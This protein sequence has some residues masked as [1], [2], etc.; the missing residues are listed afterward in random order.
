MSKQTLQK[1]IVNLVSG[2]IA[3]FFIIYSLNLIPFYPQDSRKLI[4]IAVGFLW[5]LNPILGVVAGLGILIIPITYTSLTLT[6]I[7]LMFYLIVAILE[8]WAVGP[9][10]FLVMAATV[11][12]VL[13]P[14]I[15]FLLLAIPLIAGFMGARR[16]AVLAAFS[17]F[18]AL[19][20]GLLIG[21]S[22]LGL[23]SVSS[24]IK[25]IIHLNSEPVTKMFGS[26]W[27]IA[28]TQ[29][30]LIDTALFKAVLSPFGD[31]PELL[32]Q[33]AL[34]A[35]AAGLIGYF[36]KKP[37]IKKFP[38]YE[39][40]VVI[41][42]ALLMIGTGLL[43]KAFPKSNWFMDK[44]IVSTL[45]P[46]ALVCA[47]SPG[48]IWVMP[49]ITPARKETTEEEIIV[50]SKWAE[51]NGLEQR[52]KEVKKIIDLQFNSQTR[53]NSAKENGAPPRGILFF[54]PPGTE[55]SK[56][57][58]GIADE[59]K[60]TL[61]SVNRNDLMAKYYD[62]FVSYSTRDKVAADT[63][64]ELLEKNKIH[65]WYAPRDIKPG[66]DWGKEVTNAINL[67]KQILLIF[68]RNS[69]CSQR[70][71]DEINYGIS[72]GISILPFRIENVAPNDTLM[73]HLSSRH[74]LNAFEPT[75][76]DYLDELLRLITNNLEDTNREGDSSRVQKEVDVNHYLMK[77]FEEA[78]EHH[79]SVL[80]F[81]ELIDFL[82]VS[83]QN[84]SSGISID[85]TE[86]FMEF[87]DQLANS[88]GILVVAATEYP[89]KIDEA[90]LDANRF[91]HQFYLTPPDRSTCRSILT[92]HLADKPMA[93]NVDLNKLS[94]LLDG[95]S[96][97][98][99]EALAIEMADLTESTRGTKQK[100]TGMSDFEKIIKSRKPMYTDDS[101]S[102][103]ESFAIEH[104]CIKEK[105]KQKEQ[106][107]QPVLKD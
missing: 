102:K 37:L 7:L 36:I 107:L 76:K 71:L 64:V 66:A 72:Q 74:W 23:I 106:K 1:T 17:G 99:I 48:L 15:H 21:K 96:L 49:I 57:A 65:C 47:A 27:L 40:A 34:W 39:S 98:D 4:A 18:L 52:Q 83:N 86:T 95:Y 104:G 25:P 20:L 94:T 10:G 101:L 88:P 91:G 16:G 51:S 35:V 30:G 44:F 56:V 42:M 33:I 6:I 3:C 93:L 9:F 59:A 61:I 63:C 5:F 32:V 85:S 73:L 43:P 2:V 8:T 78:Q 77:V 58:R 90:L 80:F 105:Q 11:I 100:P 81:E 41:G 89:E 19:S 75:W 103:Y 46:F 60:A 92:K 29:E 70:V 67:S 62:V 84:E 45:V 31:H 79:P 54:G 24:I 12:I 28:Q 13:H 69:N 68:S 82:G 53:K 97:S 14:E 26:G 22:H 55:K 50:T 87:M 38:A